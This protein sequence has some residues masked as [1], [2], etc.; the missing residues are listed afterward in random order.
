LK[1]SRPALVC[2]SAPTLKI[3]QAALLAREAKR[4][5]HDIHTILG[6]WHVTALPKQTLKEFSGFD[7]GVFGEGESTFL[8]VVEACVQGLLNDPCGG[9]QFF[10]ESFTV[11][12]ER[13]EKIC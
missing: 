2:F 3:K 7:I 11:I 8:E 4:F 6:G 1:R 12:P 13:T 10:D 5:D 9:L